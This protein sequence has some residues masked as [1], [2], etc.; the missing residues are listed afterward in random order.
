MDINFHQLQIFLAVARDRSFSQAA[1]KLHISQP[2]VSIQIKNLEDSFEAKLFERVSH[3]VRL[4]AEGALVLEHA[5][6]LFEAVDSLESAVQE[7]KTSHH[8]R[9]LV[10][11]S[12]VP[13]ARLVPLAVTLFKR[14]Y[15]DTEISIKT[16]R[17]HEVESWIADHEVELGIIEGDPA[18]K[19]IAK[20]PAYADELLLVLPPHS[21]LLKR[22]RWFLKDVV[23]EPLLLQAPGVRPPFIERMFAEKHLV[24][25]K[26]ITVGSRE[27]VKAAIA[28]GC[29]VS[30]LPRSVVE[31][32]I[33]TGVLKGRKVAD[34]DIRYPMTIIYRRDGTLSKPAQTFL[35]VLRKQ[36]R[37]LVHPPPLRRRPLRTIP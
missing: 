22:Q 5:K 20:E 35:H 18:D 15:P 26:P 36:G 27:A 8:A 10:G 11:C 37:Q 4:T 33:R 3:T 21:R 29:G 14:K 25:R 2:S 1:K 24:I 32:E 7:F 19:L 6:K 30:L 34:L 9:I 12:R 31:T 17:S 23:E 16:G 28:A 13:S